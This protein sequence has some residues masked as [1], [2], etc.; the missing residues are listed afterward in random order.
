VTYVKLHNNNLF[1]RAS[2]SKSMIKIPY[3]TIVQKI[4]EATQLSL[5]DIEK[6]VDEKAQQLSGLVS[7][8]G[9]AHIVA[10][11]LGVKLVDPGKQ[12]KIKDIFAGMRNVMTVGKVLQIF[13]VREFARTDGSKSKV[14]SVIV[15]DETGTIRVVCWGSQADNISKI[16]ENDILMVQSA[17]ARDSNRGYR[18]LHLNDQSKITIN[19]NGITIDAVTTTK[20]S[21]ER[22][23]IKDLR[24]EDMNVEILG[25]IVQIFDLRFFEICPECSK[26]LRRRDNVWECP[27]HMIVKEAFSY[28]FNVY[29]DDGSDN[30]RV[31][32]FRDQALTLT[33]KTDEDMN[34]YRESP[35]KFEDVKTDLLG[36][37]IK[38][39]GR[40][41]KND[42]FDRLEFVARDIV[43]DPNPEEELARLE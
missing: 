35:E 27:Q 2:A 1:K 16:K 26:R 40:I 36:E 6:K 34:I 29:L 30:I 8:G 32:F 41:K 22:K 18:E 19:P 13:D 17:Y 15:G 3:E 5:E 14:G 10:N 7:K 39:T 33:K 37:I 38:V 31:V 21:T 25:T 9:A 24:E 4:H 42:F 20:Q 11:E 43:L 28:V 23:S 12:V